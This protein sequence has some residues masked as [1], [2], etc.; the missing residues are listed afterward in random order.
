MSEDSGLSLLQQEMQVDEINLRVNAIHRLKTVILNM[1]TDETINRVLPYLESL[2]SIEDDEVLFAI[3]EEI[4]QVFH[5]VPD[6]TTFLPLLEELAS[7][8]ETVVRE[9]A[10]KSLNKICKELSDAEI[11]NVF[12]PLV[13]K[14]ATGDQFPQ[15]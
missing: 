2:I 4:G 8:S 14:L 6:N 7:Q 5:L 15:R 3:S 10:A 13:I 1:G 11:Q 12:A 9:E